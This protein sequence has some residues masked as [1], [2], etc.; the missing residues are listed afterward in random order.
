MTKHSQNLTKSN[1]ELM[2]QTGLSP[3]E[4]MVQAM[5]PLYMDGDKKATYLG[6]LVAGFSRVEAKRLTGIHDKTLTRWTQ[7]DP[8]FVAFVAKIPDVRKDLSNQLLDIEYTRNFKLVLAK[9][10]KV[11]Y[12]DA[13][14]KTLNEQE[15]QYLAIIRKFYTPQHLALLRQLLAGDGKVGEDALDWT[16]TVLEIRLSREETRG[17]R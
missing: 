1:T 9:D 14:G 16:K 7:G 15:Q 10:F 5:L 11:L 2:E 13:T 12:K 4:G 8:D 6:Y 17:V 3:T